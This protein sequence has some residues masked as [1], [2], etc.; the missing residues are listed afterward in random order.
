M[1]NT[2][3]LPTLAD[4]HKTPEEAFKND[5]F[6]SILNTPP[7]QKWI[8]K[9]KFADNSDYLPIDKVEFLLDSI[10]QLW[11]VEVRQVQQLLTSI[12]VTIRLHYLHPVT[13][14]WSFHDGVAAKEIQTK[15]GSGPLK[16]D[17]SNISPGALQM[18]VPIAKS[19][20]IRDAADHLG[21]IFGRDLNRK[22]TV[23]FAGKYSAEPGPGAGEH[24]NTGADTNYGGDGPVLPL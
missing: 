15:A 6:L 23:E 8:K 13:G 18:A 24:L 12:E 21:K 1:S 4:L 9:N 14:E 5:S 7:P 22:D 10:F 16:H 20:A 17:L 11:K 2:R 3:N 19:I